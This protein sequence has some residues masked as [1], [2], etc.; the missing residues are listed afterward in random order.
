MDSYESPSVPEGARQ[1]KMRTKDGPRQV[2]PHS[3]EQWKPALRIFQEQVEA[4]DFE[5]PKSRKQL[6]EFK[7][8][9]PN[10]KD[11]FLHQLAIHSDKDFWLDSSGQVS[12]QSTE[13]LKWIIKT[14]NL[15]RLFSKHV[16]PAGIG[17]DSERDELTP[18]QFAIDKSNHYFLECFLKVCEESKD[19]AGDARKLLQKQPLGKDQDN[20]LH[21]AIAKKLPWVQRMVALCDE[22]A[23]R[24][25]NS[26][27]NTPLH[28]AMTKDNGKTFS[29]RPTRPTD[30]TP[31]SSKPRAEHQEYEF[32]T[33]RIFD[34]LE[35][36]DMSGELLAELLT[37]TNSSGLS[38]Y[39]LRIQTFSKEESK[40][41]E[42]DFQS[43]LSDFIFS[44]IPHIPDVSRAL[45]GTRGK[46]HPM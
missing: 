22:Q 11:T 4:T 2:V 17:V 5:S 18:L 39:Q 35:K 27:G 40:P 24:D 31:N 12:Q 23:L 46:S 45:Y 7:G 43:K 19:D 8:L 14:D 10:F 44:K 33:P 36:R 26:A 30:V 25:T 1:G 29:T 9:K 13:L 38:P 32:R 16:T 37:K 15:R 34:E 20:C 41:S 21:R 3:N 28:L 6:E 42:I